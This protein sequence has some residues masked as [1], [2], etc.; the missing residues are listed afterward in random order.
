MPPERGRLTAV[1]L[2]L[3]VDL[4]GFSIVFPL[5]PAM[6]A[7]YSER[8][9][10]VL[11][12]WMAPLAA[13]FPDSDPWQRAALFGGLL[14][15]L[16]AGLQFLAAPLWGRWSDRRGRRPVLLWSLA[17][18]LLANALW[19]F[20]SDFLLL[21][22]SRIIAGAMTGNVAVAQAAVSDLTDSA[23]RSRGMAIVG[24]AFG[25]GFIIGPAL[26]GW[27]GGWR[28]DH[29][30][31]PG[32][33]PFSVPA[34]AACA[35]SAINLL[36]VA[37]AFRETLDPAQRARAAARPGR[38]WLPW[39]QGLPRR[40]H[41]LNGISFVHTFWFSG[42]EMTLGFL[43]MQ[44]LGLGPAALGLAFAGMGL[45]SAAVQGALVRPW[46]ARL[47]MSRLAIAGCLA[48]IAGFLSL[49]ALVVWPSAPAFALALALHAIGCGL[50]FPS[51]ATLVSLEAA[52]DQQGLAL[53]GFRSAAALGRTL[54]PLL[55]AALYFASPA[56]AY[57]LAA[58]GMLA[59]ALWIS[60]L[61]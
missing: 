7:W 51:L 4:V 32:L 59:L 50:L 35:L 18:S 45:G 11:H 25:L 1:F 10:D 34:L 15:A 16:Y 42:L 27:L 41:A 56:L 29:L 13:V 53:G 8:S 5:F 20:A 38:G 26:G 54:G 57:A 36:W 3:F 58:G 28:L 23:G 22:L 19:V 48:H 39:R 17:G 44:Y 46:G 60:S 21:A 24:M 9:G 52:S 43:A 2:V 33:H 31:L 30:P 14:G 40:V 49:L 37:L 55:V 6:L 12:R 47:G 61:R